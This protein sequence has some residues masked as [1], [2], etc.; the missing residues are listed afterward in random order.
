MQIAERS[1]PA[2]RIRGGLP[3]RL[4]ALL[5]GLAVFAAGIVAL[6][7]SRLGLSPWDV[8]HQ[9]IARHTALSFGEANIA[10]GVV[11]LL[12]AV[13]LGARAGIGTVA[14]AVLVGTFVHVLASIHA[15]E[16]L[17]HAPLPAR[18]GLLAAGL[19]LMAA[20]TALYVGAGLGAG[21]RDSL[22][23]VGARRTPL[24]LGAVRAAIELC[25]LAAGFA[26]GGTVG[27]GTLAFAV[28]IGPLVEGCFALLARSPLARPAEPAP[29][30]AVDRCCATALEAA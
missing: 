2:P 22:M 13:A 15:I 27:V 29:A 3:A 28:G 11:V 21:P 25:A 17:A 16:R 8:L 14:N 4:A 1:Q 10:V 26:L 9:G 6:L 7:E 24:R 5:A 12:L 19:V 30:P 20:G 18:A 23:L